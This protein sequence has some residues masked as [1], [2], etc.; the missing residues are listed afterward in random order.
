MQYQCVFAK[1]FNEAADAMSK[2]DAVVVPS[3]TEPGFC[4]VYATQGA[5][6]YLERLITHDLKGTK[7][8]S[9]IVLSI[10]CYSVPFPHDIVMLFINVILRL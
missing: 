3:V 10:N 5:N 8:L 1:D 9:S 2:Y 6:A 4:Y 7:E